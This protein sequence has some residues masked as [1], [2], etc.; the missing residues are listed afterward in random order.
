LA[1][2]TFGWEKRNDSVMEIN[3]AQDTEAIPP[4]SWLYMSLLQQYR[5]FRGIDPKSTEI[6]PDLR[7]LSHSGYKFQRLLYRNDIT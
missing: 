1:F 2:H 7:G 3:R 5:M 4:F 6:H